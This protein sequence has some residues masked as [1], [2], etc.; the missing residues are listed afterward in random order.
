MERG[1]DKLAAFCQQ[2]I[3][4][5]CKFELRYV[6]QML[7]SWTCMNLDRFLWFIAVDWILWDI[8]KVTGKFKWPE[9]KGTANLRVCS[10]MQEESWTNVGALLWDCK[11]SANLG[12][13]PVI[14]GQRGDAG[15]SKLIPG[16]R[17]SLSCTLL[18]VAEQPV[19]E[20]QRSQSQVPA[21]TNKQTNHWRRK[22]Q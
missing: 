19:E 7:S 21:K 2:V 13:A 4:F 15:G 10:G 9:I 1:Q 22:K 14:L 6:Y 17:Q 11:S 3:Y 5:H 18:I 20:Q 8:I 12:L 16:L